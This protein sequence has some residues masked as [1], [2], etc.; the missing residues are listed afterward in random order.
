ML[1]RLEHMKVRK[2]TRHDTVAPS[3]KALDPSYVVEADKW[4]ADVR[5]DLE[6]AL[7]PLAARQ[8]KRTALDLA[9]AGV[10]EKMHKRGLG[11]PNGKSAITKV[12][13][14]PD[15]LT[16]DV[17]SKVLDMAEQAAQRQSERIADLIKQMDADGASL[18]EIKKAVKDMVDARGSWR[19]GLSIHASTA[20]MEGVKAAV[21]GEAKTLITRRWNTQEDERVRA[22]H[23]KA[24][25]KTRV[26]N[27]PF[28]V[29][30]A[31]MMFPGDPTA[32]VGETANCR[33]YLTWSAS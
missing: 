5:R 3:T 23:R 32:P 1:D 14:D 13:A 6:A 30:G 28:K 19:R 20:M 22:T 2:H 18:K 15:A 8:A 9:H 17:V 12:T 21:Y 25:G 7:K 26:S 11:N 31:P 33:C 10:I 16:N 24:H 29:G 4:K 27:R